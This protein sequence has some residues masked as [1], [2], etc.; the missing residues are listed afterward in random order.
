M[1]LFETVRMRAPPSDAAAACWVACCVACCAAMSVKAAP[2][3]AWATYPAA[4][5][6][7]G[8]A[9]SIRDGTPAAAD[10]AAAE[11]AASLWLG[12]LPTSGSSPNLKSENERS[13]APSLKSAA[14]FMT[15]ESRES[16]EKSSVSFTVWSGLNAASSISIDCVF[17]MLGCTS[18]STIIRR[19]FVCAPSP[20]ALLSASTPPAPASASAS[21][22]PITTPL[23][24]PGRPSPPRSRMRVS[25]S[26]V[27]CSIVLPISSIL[28][29]SCDTSFFS[30]STIST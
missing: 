19:F 9:S 29:L 6:A 8:A 24:I 12:S 23:P 3:A 4:C 30:S 26:P 13:S 5:C 15:V 18:R 27:K 22:S 21:N 10:A 2:R 1:P 7:M 14:S 11:K 20:L 25:T 28:P 16:W 17:T